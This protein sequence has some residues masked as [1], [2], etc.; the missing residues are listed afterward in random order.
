MQSHI[1]DFHNSLGKEKQEA[2]R[3]PAQISAGGRIKYA[4]SAR[5]P[6]SDTNGDKPDKSMENVHFKPGLAIEVALITTSQCSKKYKD[7]LS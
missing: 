3:F 7:H 2:F 1:T 5:Y 4:T 6:G